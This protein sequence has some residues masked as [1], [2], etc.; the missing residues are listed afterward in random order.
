ME[1]SEIRRELRDRGFAVEETHIS[2]VFLGAREVFKIKKPVDLGFLDFTTLE[3]R[4]RACHAEVELNRRLTRDVYLGV[5]PLVRGPHGDL[6]F[7][8]EG[9]VVDWSVH[10]RR[11]SRERRADRLLA[12]D[13]LDFEQIEQVAAVVE[14]FHAAARSDAE[15]TL[16]GSREVVSGNVRENFEQTADSIVEYLS[17]SQVE[18]VENWQLGFLEDNA[19]L[20]EHREAEGRIRDGHG[21]LRLEHVYL[22]AEA[23]ADG[24]QIVDCI[25]FNERFRFADGCADVAFLAMDLGYCGRV[26]LA[27]TFLAAYAR[28]SNDYGLYSL[29]DF[30]ESYRAFVRAKV[31]SFL[32]EDQGAEARTRERAREEVRRYY[33]LSLASERRRLQRPRLVAV[34]GVIA[35]GKSTVAEAVGRRLAAPVIAADP[36]RKFLLGKAETE[37][38]HVAAFAGPYSAEMTDRVY[39]EI[40]D[41]AEIVLRSGRPAVL[42]ASFRDRGL[43]QRSRQLAQRLGVPFL[44]VECRAPESVC[45]ERLRRRERETSVSDGRLEIFD[46]FVASWEPVDELSAKE[47]LLVDTSRPLAETVAFLEARIPLWPTAASHR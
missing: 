30:Y 35:S 46:E 4:R 26:D 28:A 47:H 15:V 39:Q 9:E 21:D 10:M 14:R 12:H 19:E 7:G 8:G 16:A 32:V 29:V 45:R 41:R 23:P 27:E 25:E 2:L 36:T 5:V 22:P 42:D 18:E 34:G 43:R 13:R 11:L 37:K 38:V 3:R 1:P 33:L 20:F 31:A 44:F 6:A 24:I 17:P 40:F